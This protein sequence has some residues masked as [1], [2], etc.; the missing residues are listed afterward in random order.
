MPTIVQTGFQLATSVIS[1]GFVTGNK[2]LN[3]NNLLLT[4]SKYAQSNASAGT[5][6]DV[7]IGNFNLANVPSNAVVTGIEIEL[8]NAYSGGPISPAITITPYFVDNTSGSNVYYPYVTPQTLSITPTN[9]T[10][11]S[12]T[13]TFETSFT[14]N[15][16][17]NAKIQLIA[18][19]ATFVDAVKINVFYYVPT[20]IT[21]PPPVGTGCPDCN[22][23]IQAP[24]F[25][26]ALPFLSGDRYAYF[27]SFNYANNVPINFA[28]LGSCGGSI[29]FTFDPELTQTG[30]TGN[31]M[32]NARTAVWTVLSNGLVQFDFND[33]SINRGLMFHTPY[34]ADPTLRSNHDANS[35][36]VISDNG[37]FMGQYLQKCQI[38]SV[39]SAPIV[40]SYAGSPI[41]NPTANLNFIGAGVTVIQNGT[42]PTQA[43]ITIPGYAVT[44]PNIVNDINY[45]SGST[46][47][48]SITVPFT[49]T[50]TDRDLVVSFTATSGIA[51][52]SVTWNAVGLTLVGSSTNGTFTTYVYNLV[53]PSLGTQNMV[54]T[55]A[56]AS[57]ISGGMIAYTQVNQSTPTNAL[58][59]ASGNSSNAGVNVTTT[60]QNA[61]VVHAVGTSHFPM[62]FTHGGGENLITS[63]VTG[64]LQN[65]IENQSVG[66][67]ATVTTQI[68][69]SA[70]TQWADVA[71]ALNGITPP[72]TST[73]TARDEGSVIDSAVVNINFVGAGV[74]ATQTAPGFIQVS[75][76]GG[77][78]GGA[79]VT[80][81][82]QTP[83]DGT[84]GTLAGAVN[85]INTVFT[86]SQSAYAS[87]GLVVYLNGLI[88]L[89][90]TTNDW[91]ETNPALGTFTFN[92]APLTGDIIT[93]MYGITSGLLL[94][95][96][97]VNN[98]SQIK[99]NLKNGAGISVTDDGSGGI[100][101]ANT[102]S[103]PSINP[104]TTCF[105]F[106]DFIGGSTSE[107]ANITTNPLVGLLGWSTTGSGGRGSIQ[108]STGSASHPGNV[109]LSTG[110]L[111]GDIFAMFLQ[112]NLGAINTKSTIFETSIKETTLP[113]QTFF[114]LSDGTAG[115]GD[116][117]A[118]SYK[119]I[120]FVRTTASGNWVGYA[121]DATTQNTTSG[122]AITAGGYD[123]LNVSI[124]ATGA[125][126]TFTVNGVLLGT[127]AIPSASTPDAYIQI[128]NNTGSNAVKITTVD[129]FTFLRTLTR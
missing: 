120:G 59:T 82:D 113:L 69:L 75:V 93:V 86:V 4:D 104:A 63:S 122:V 119:K 108:N 34:T 101:I 55:M 96:N 38:G 70:S 44:P 29:T 33:I 52:S 127:I 95:T 21:P 106:D 53:A 12:S 121:S 67:P 30:T 102:G 92:I 35:T 16:I 47:V 24:A 73:L 123:K 85:G 64:L 114:G 126:A 90:G 100:T 109:Q 84:Y 31:F 39:V 62:L 26:L 118:L 74:T 48:T 65:A 18:N 25:T 41:V 42:F 115:A 50:G 129:Y 68:G 19:G 105:L 117:T 89:Q 66:T 14:Q 49:V 125:N 99:L 71:F 5:A 61:I 3:P 54:I 20:A 43:D 87:G 91:Q 10:L 81:I 40:T 2:W 56:S 13:Y 80:Q 103:G 88:Q 46:P 60:L 78:G 111:G 116:F 97:S 76:P 28:D 107:N 83:D 1:N 124:D 23:P 6:S 58:A 45:T 9:Y 15:Q 94:Q 72:A 36:V 37:P 8:V 7:I 32:E 110:N 112:G 128:C 11:G 51:V 57:L 98:G 27:K 77:G 79:S 17:N 22:S